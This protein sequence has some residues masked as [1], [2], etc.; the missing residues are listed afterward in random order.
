MTIFTAQHRKEEKEKEGGK[1]R[2]ARIICGE[3]MCRN[4]DQ[5]PSLF[6]TVQYVGTGSRGKDSAEA[7]ATTFSVYRPR[8][9]PCMRRATAAGGGI[10]GREG[11]RL[12]GSA[13][14]AWIVSQPPS[15]SAEPPA[16]PPPPP[17]PM[18]GVT[19]GG[20]FL[21]SILSLSLC[22]PSS[23]S[24]LASSAFYGSFARGSR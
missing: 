17:P 20:G 6:S 13:V 7:A 9:P 16:P 22:P 19:E 18:G 8:P 11:G 23:S 10:E 12:Q 14:V 24:G 3:R 5:A 15:S 4:S 21:E 1:I 2:A